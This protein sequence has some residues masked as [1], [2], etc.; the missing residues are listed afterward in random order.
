MKG[1]IML[2]IAVASV[3][4]L[5]IAQAGEIGHFNGGIIDMRDYFMPGP[6]IYGAVYNYN[7]FTD[8]LND[9]SGNKISSETINTPGGPV[10]ANLNVKI[11]MYALFPAIIW[12]S[13][14]KI[15]GARYG[16][17]IAPSFANISL[18]AKLS[19]ANRVGGTI[20][21][22]NTSLGVGDLYVRPVWLD[23]AE[24][25]WDFSLAYGF[26]AP[27]GKYNTRSVTLP[28]GASATVELK[29]NIGLGFWTQQVQA[30]VAWY[31]MTNK[32][33]AVT[34]VG[35]YEYNGPKKDFDLRPGQ[36]FTVNWGVSRYLPLCENHQLLLEVGPA[37]YD[38]YQI[39]D[40]TGA[41]ALTDTPKSRVHGLGGQLGLVYVPWNAFL[42]LHGFGEYAAISR[43][44]GASIGLNF[45]IKF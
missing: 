30:G 11:H 21:I 5:S 16:G 34:L 27:V 40:S 31:P 15:L 2:L 26:Y 4:N 19:I 14:Y 39:T 29:N 23:W 41:N 37:G 43:F 1:N 45:G 8:R 38:S 42:T 28:G 7:Y 9:G 36:M 12:S 44:Q 32:A 20:N 22:N 24:N 25:H 18:D 35:T 17:Y 10:P 13:P 33:T 6:G 3:A